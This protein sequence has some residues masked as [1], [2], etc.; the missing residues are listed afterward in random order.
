M[1]S[2][3]EKTSKERLIENQSPQKIPVNNSRRHNAS[4]WVSFDS[5]AL[6]FVWFGIVNFLEEASASY[7]KSQFIF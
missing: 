2:A 7:S 5:F 4:N 1:Y 6:T 3:N